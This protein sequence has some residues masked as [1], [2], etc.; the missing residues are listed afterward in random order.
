MAQCNGCEFETKQNLLVLTYRDDISLAT[1][2]NIN[3]YFIPLHLR[4]GKKK[5]QSSDF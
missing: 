3:T 1:T 2:T 4:N 5:S